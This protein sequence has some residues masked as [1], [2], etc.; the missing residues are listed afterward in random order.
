MGLILH[1][2]MSHLTLQI[3][4]YGIEHK[5]R[6]SQHL[7]HSFKDKY[8]IS[9][10]CSIAFPNSRVV[11]FYLYTSIVNIET[12][13]FLKKTLQRSHINKNK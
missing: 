8:R 9:I 11:S 5:T 1:K 13:D 4:Q 6:Q 12:N 3:Y 7:Y 10:G 2:V